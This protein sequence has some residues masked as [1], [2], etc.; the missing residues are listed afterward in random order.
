MIGIFWEVRKTM[1]RRI[2]K[3]KTYPNHTRVSFMLTMLAILIF[4]YLSLRYGNETGILGMWGK[5]SYLQLGF[6][7]TGYFGYQ[8]ITNQPIFPKQFRELD[9]DTIIFSV[10]VLVI[11]L[12]LQILF[13][14]LITIT[15]FEQAMFTLGAAIAEELFFRAFLISLILYLIGDTPQN[16]IIA[17]I[18][19]SIS[20]AFAHVNYYGDWAVLVSIFT[21]G[22]VYS[23]AFLKT[24][25]IT[26][27][28]LAHL[29]NN[30][31][32][33]MQMIEYGVL[34]I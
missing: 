4:G 27:P 8:A 25:N 21:S 5:F 18:I 22:I 34:V 3:E 20:F 29:F 31:I 23:I 15:G 17:V 14:I 6:I 13:G 9:L 16:R 12:G 19:S 30:L 24:K 26:I 10:L 32:V 28:I 7:L 1:P 11:V 2:K 33:V